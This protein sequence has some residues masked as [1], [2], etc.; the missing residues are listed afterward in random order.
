MVIKLLPGEETPKLP[1]FEE[2]W[3]RFYHVDGDRD[4]VVYMEIHEDCSK[5]CHFRDEP[6]FFHPEGCECSLGQCQIDD[7][8]ETIIVEINEEGLNELKKPI[9]EAIKERICISCGYEAKVFIDGVSK[10]EYYISGLCQTCQD[11]VFGKI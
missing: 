2:D 4:N 1:Y 3:F 6:C 11:W 5:K 8:T 9:K 10:K 7:K